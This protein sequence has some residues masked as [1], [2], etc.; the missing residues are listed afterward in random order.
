MV[1]RI[2]DGWVTSELRADEW[3]KKANVVSRT[4]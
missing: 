2:W 3:G 1:K 4:G